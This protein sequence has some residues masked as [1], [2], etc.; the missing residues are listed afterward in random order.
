MTPSHAA[1]GR[2]L[3]VA[4]PA[5]RSE[6]DG[7][8][9]KAA[10]AKSKS[11]PTADCA[12]KENDEADEESGSK[13]AKP[14]VTA[15]TDQDELP[16]ET[17]TEE[18]ETKSALAGKGSNR[19]KIL[20]DRIKAAG[21]AKGFQSD[22]EGD[23]QRLNEGVDVRLKR[24]NFRIACEVSITT[25]VDHEFCNIEKCLRESSDVI[26]KGKPP[27]KPGRLPEFDRSGSPPTGEK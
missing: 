19:H 18:T 11:T 22:I 10:K 26:K 5:R 7:P 6:W 14:P 16:E 20:Q 9:A 17:E 13:P 4:G 3:E 2:E 23:T 27:A 1:L 24:G 25:N 21:I 8:D 15:E 12:H